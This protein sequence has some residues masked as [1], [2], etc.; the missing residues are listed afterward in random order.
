VPIMAIFQ[1]EVGV[2][3]VVKGPWEGWVKMVENSIGDQCNYIQ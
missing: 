2:M 1:Q 3:V